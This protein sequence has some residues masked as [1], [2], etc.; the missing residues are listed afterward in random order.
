MLYI[1]IYLFNSTLSLSTIRKDF[2]IN[3]R[4]E[5]LTQPEAAKLNV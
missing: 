1:Y 5:M 2:F 3:T 4:A